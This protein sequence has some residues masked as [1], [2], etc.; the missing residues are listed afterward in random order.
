MLTSIMGM[1]K[2]ILAIATGL[3][4]YSH[5]SINRTRVFIVLGR[6]GVVSAATKLTSI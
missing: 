3:R 5:A 6:G 2:I 1:Q 4:L